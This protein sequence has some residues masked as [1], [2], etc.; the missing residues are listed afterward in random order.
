M[1]SLG[2]SAH[3]RTPTASSPCHHDPLPISEPGLLSL[4]T[5]HVS[6]IWKFLSNREDLS[7]ALRISGWLLH[8][9]VFPEELSVFY[10]FAYL[11]WG[12]VW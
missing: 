9:I 7:Q 11:L 12:V 5:R 4:L 8:I 3:P 10:W 1:H 6:D 2:C